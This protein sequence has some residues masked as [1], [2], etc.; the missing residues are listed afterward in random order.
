MLF[1]YPMMMKR[2]KVSEFPD[3][4]KEVSTISEA[5]LQR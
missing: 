4:V 2:E 5:C 1:T 3:A